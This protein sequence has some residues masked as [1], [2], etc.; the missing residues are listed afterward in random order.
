MSKRQ[1]SNSTLQP[2]IITITISI[3]I[4]ISSNSIIHGG[5][6]FGGSVEWH[7]PVVSNYVSISGIPFLSIDYR[8]TPEAKNEHRP[9]PRIAV[10]GDSAGGGLTLLARERNGLKIAKQVLVYPMLDDKSTTPKHD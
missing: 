4:S 8:L 3:T 10:M 6:F 1:I 9:C 5:G 7:K 2:I